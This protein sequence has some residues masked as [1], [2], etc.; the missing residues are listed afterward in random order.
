[1]KQRHLNWPTQ[2]IMAFARWTQQTAENSITALLNFI[3]FF[4]CRISSKHLWSFSACV[5]VNL[6][7]ITKPSTSMLKQ[8]GILVDWAFINLLLNLI[9]N[10]AGGIQRNLGISCRILIFNITRSLCILC[11]HF[12]PFRNMQERMSIYDVYPL[13]PQNPDSGCF[14]CINF[15]PDV[16]ENGNCDCGVSEILSFLARLCSVS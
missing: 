1:M 10:W 6:I 8:G 5:I 15:I 3:L 11:S 14:D 16:P 2:K 9:R 4:L 13:T 7:R 12:C